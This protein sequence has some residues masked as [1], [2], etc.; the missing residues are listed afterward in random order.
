MGDVGVF[1]FFSTENI[2]SGS[3]Y[4]STNKPEKSSVNQSINQSINQPTNIKPI[5]RHKLHPTL[6]HTALFNA[7]FQLGVFIAHREHICNPHYWQTAKSLTLDDHGDKTVLLALSVG[8]RFTITNGHNELIDEI[9][10]VAFGE[11]VHELLEI[12]CL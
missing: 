10:R 7:R 1:L 5:E 6:V 11:H 4:K 12:V 3:E 9:V 2:S 8:R